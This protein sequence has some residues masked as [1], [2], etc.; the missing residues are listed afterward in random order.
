[1][2]G[3]GDYL[4][5]PEKYCPSKLLGFG[6]K[7][8]SS[9]EVIASILEAGLGPGV[10]Q[11]IIITHSGITHLQ[12]KKYLGNLTRRGFMEMGFE[13]GRPVYRTSRKGHHFLNQYYLLMQM[14]INSDAYIGQID[15]GGNEKPVLG[16][17]SF[18][19]WMR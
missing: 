12:F 16:I 8:R 19:K 17:G 2:R 9:L 3:F 13:K 18:P 7:Y 4:A 10:A 14:L 5:Y 11:R 1:M 15:M 6:V